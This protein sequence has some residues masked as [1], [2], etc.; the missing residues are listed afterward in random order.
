[1]KLKRD[2]FKRVGPTSRFGKFSLVVA[3]AYVL[4][5]LTGKL[6]TAPAWLGVLV[7]LAF[8]VV[9]VRYLFKWMR[10]ASRKLLW[11]LRRR[12]VVTYLLAGVL[13]IVLLFFIM[14]I[15]G[16]AF[17]GQ[18][19]SHFVASDL[20]R[21]TNKLEMTNQSLSGILLAK[22]SAGAVDP[23]TLS[24]EYS[25]LWDDLGKN[26]SGISI[27]VQIRSNRIAFDLEDG[28]LVGGRVPISKPAWLQSDISGL[29]GDSGKI[30]FVSFVERRMQGA[31]GWVIIRAPLDATALG[32]L[33]ERNQIAMR[34]LALQP[35]PPGA[36]PMGNPFTIDGQ[37]Y[38][39]KD[40]RQVDPT[41]AAQF[42][43]RLTW[44]DFPTLSFPF[45]LPGARSWA[46]GK[47]LVQL[48]G[49]YL[50]N[51]TWLRLAKRLFSEGIAG[52]ENVIASALI[53]VSVF[54][55][56]IECVALL[57]SLLMTRTITGAVHNLD[58]GTQHIMRGDFSHRIPVKV[59]DQL[60][61]LG[62]TFNTMTA[63]IERL[64]KEQAEKQRLESELAIALEVQKQ[65]FPREAP[66]L[67]HLQI[68]GVCNPARIVSG[69]YYDFL[70]I[71]PTTVGL[72][73]GDVSGKG[74]SA[75]LL[76]ASLQAALRSHSVP[77]RLERASTLESHV[78]AAVQAASVSSHVA[79]IVSLLN[80]QLYHNSPSEKYVTFFYSVY[81][82]SRRL[83]TYTNAGHLPP[84]IFNARGVRRLEA[85]GTVLGLLP[86]PHY[87]Q[88]GI[89]FELGDVLVAYTDGITEAE[90][91]FEEQF[92]EKRLIETVGRVVNRSPDEILHAIL[93]AVANWVETGEPQDDMTL[94][95]AKAT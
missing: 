86:D 60:S 53:V 88:E 69:D 61:S 27:D 24:R 16:M 64:L 77:G 43:Q 78:S 44:Y 57:S 87:E 95:V 49:I 92:G 22:L 65:L 35:V 84:L 40:I 62:E 5:K 3:I 26:F 76:M 68:A 14:I 29:F 6:W 37:Q 9:A 41:N 20:D 71:A 73:L 30:F 46:D 63:S 25:G 21:M 7:G 45:L 58:E 32:R 54:F 80:E 85:G 70:L 42:T 79:E 36:R 66:R 51:S 39:Q 83:L 31:T 23:A 90:N 38:V 94:I 13:P 50:M 72:A 74:V 91:S 15:L 34:I 28:R 10:W 4:L 56:I 67:G 59:R 55:L 33:S 93:D 47:L 12:L 81:D 17:L 82:D 89:T 1:M 75:A 18:L 11:R 8:F 19:G 48:P 2:M 52:G